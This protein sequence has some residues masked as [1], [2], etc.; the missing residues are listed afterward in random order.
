M[1]VGILGAFI[2][3]MEAAG[4]ALAGRARYIPLTKLLLMMAVASLVLAATFP[5]GGWIV[6]LMIGGY[7]TVFGMSSTL[8]G[9][10]LQGATQGP[11]RATVTSVAGFGENIGA[12]LG[13]MAFGVVAEYFGMNGGTLATGVVAALLALGFIALGN[14]W[15]ITRGSESD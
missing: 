10:E 3:A 9:A 2:S 12:I 11:A 15:G 4:M 7:F 14:A 8:F 5:F 1:W 6:P 13:F